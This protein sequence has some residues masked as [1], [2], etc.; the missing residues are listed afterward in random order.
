MWL[1]PVGNWLMVW[2]LL[3]GVANGA[4]TLNLFSVAQ[5]F[6]GPGASGTWVGVQNGLA[7]ISGI[8]GPIVTGLIIDWSGSYAGAFWVAAAVTLMGA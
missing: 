2:L 4:G 8:V 7:N 3:A 1:T 6:A 5:M